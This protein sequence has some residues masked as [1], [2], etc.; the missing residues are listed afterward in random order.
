MVNLL[1]PLMFWFMLLAPLAV[2]WKHVIHVRGG[3]QSK[4]RAIAH[5]LSYSAMPIVLYAV[6]F[7]V[8]VGFEEGLDRS[9]IA[10]EVAR[11]FLPLVAVGSI[12]VILAT[13]IFAGVVTFLS[14]GSS[15]EP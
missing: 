8:L 5:F 3:R 2:G 6:G 7:L 14:S 1:I 4:P 11:S 15:A 10:E 9:L 12:W 13:A